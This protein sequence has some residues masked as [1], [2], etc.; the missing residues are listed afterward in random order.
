MISN[1]A[2]NFFWTKK[3]NNDNFIYFS[4]WIV[5]GISVVEADGQIEG[6]Q[7]E[8]NEENPQTYYRGITCRNIRCQSDRECVNCRN[9][10]PATCRR[11]NPPICDPVSYEI[12]III[13]QFITHLY[14]S[15]L[16]IRCNA[17]CQ[18]RRGF[19]LDQITN[20]CVRLRDCTIVAPG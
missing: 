13:Y 9:P 7:M 6:L 18:C 16:Q 17:G 4:R 19:V 15:L 12:F 20:R 1:Q 2:K 11:P 14:I 8:E 10:C 3:Y 5:D